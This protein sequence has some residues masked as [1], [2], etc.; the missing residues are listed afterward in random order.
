MGKSI[1]FLIAN[2]KNA[3][4]AT[5]AGRGMLISITISSLSSIVVP[6][7]FTA[8]K[9]SAATSRFEVLMPAFKAISAGAVSLG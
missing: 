2:L 3:L 4:L 9:S 6:E 7:T 5:L 8:K 1:D